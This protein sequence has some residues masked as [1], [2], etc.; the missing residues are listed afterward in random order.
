MIRILVREEISRRLLIELLDAPTRKKLDLC[1]D[2]A[3]LL[4]NKGRPEISRWVSLCPR[5]ILAL[6]L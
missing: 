1:P 2:L 5:P 4:E 3:L 6:T